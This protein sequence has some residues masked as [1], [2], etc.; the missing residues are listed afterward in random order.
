MDHVICTHGNLYGS[1]LVLYTTIVGAILLIASPVMTLDEILMFLC[2]ASQILIYL[3]LPAHVINA[4]NKYINLLQR[5]VRP[6]NE[7]MP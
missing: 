2:L 6:K 3:G 7:I 1:G 4:I 5:N